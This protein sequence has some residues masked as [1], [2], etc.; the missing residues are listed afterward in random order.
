MKIKIEDFKQFVED[1]TVCFTKDTNKKL[2]I[3]LTGRYEI[4]YKNEIVLITD[5]MEVAV[6]KYNSL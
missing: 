3:T 4:V 5:N 6:D 2:N 1:T